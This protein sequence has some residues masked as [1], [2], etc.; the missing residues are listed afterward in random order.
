MKK[1]SPAVIIAI[2]AVVLAIVLMAIYTLV[3][4]KSLTS[5]QG[6]N[7]GGNLIEP[8]ISLQILT[9]GENLSSVKIKAEA[10]PEDKNG[11]KSIILPDGSSVD[12]AVAEFE[13]FKNDTYTFKAIGNNG[14]EKSNSI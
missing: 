7:K 2:I 8:S 3:L 1:M 12:G 6:G 10:T 11:I 9:Q 14:A 4:G 13:V 5:G